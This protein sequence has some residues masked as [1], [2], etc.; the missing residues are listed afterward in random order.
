MSRLMAK[1]QDLKLSWID[2]RTLKNPIERKAEL[3]EVKNRQINFLAWVRAIL[4]GGTVSFR[5]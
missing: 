2:G 3:S 1:G 4:Q 5:L